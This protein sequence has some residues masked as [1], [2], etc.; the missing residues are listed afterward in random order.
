MKNFIETVQEIISF[1]PRQLEGEQKTAEYLI[2]FLRDAGI[3]FFTEEFTVDIPLVKQASLIVD[4][5]SMVC[6]GSCF[7][8]GK[9]SGK[10]H[11]ISSLYFDAKLDQSAHI[12]F[13]PQCTA[14]S[15]PVYYHVPSIAVTPTSMHKIIDADHVQGQ[16]D[17]ER[18]KHRS[19]HILVGN[20]INPTK[21]CFAH[22]DSIKMGAVDNAS[23]VSIMMHL[24]KEHPK[25]LKHTL[26]V[27][28]ANE[29][30]S[31]DEG[32]YWGH[33]YR[34]F[35]KVYESVMMQAQ[36]IIV[37]DS[38]GNGIA[39]KISDKNILK[40][41]FPIVHM[42]EWYE[43]IFFIAGDFGHLMTIYH[44]DHDDGRGMT[45][46]HMIQAYDKVCDALDI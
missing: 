5:E 19:V 30:L 23:G 25:S 41:G 18:I 29:E 12:N 36:Q 32:I 13:N 24:I 44:S 22:Y 9:I 6:E 4:E 39:K 46:G 10:D 7:V 42:E 34:E 3:P 17:V 8:S 21:I 20:V 11:I 14:I 37:I 15:L 16:V 43:K 40:M 1:S 38:V 27:F 2:T 45:E 35:E 28:A 33:G 31:Y 26:Y